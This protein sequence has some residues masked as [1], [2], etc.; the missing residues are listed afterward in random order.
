MCFPELREKGESVK[1]ED[2]GEAAAKAPPKRVYRE[3]RGTAVEAVRRGLQ[4]ENVARAQSEASD[5]ESERQAGCM[6]AGSAATQH[7]GGD[8]ACGVLEIRGAETHRRW[9]E[10]LVCLEGE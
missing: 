7:M 6:A 9:K 1:L 10:R 2:V 3:D 8:T 5:P 4:G